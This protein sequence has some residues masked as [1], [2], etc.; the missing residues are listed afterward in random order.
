MK[1]TTEPVYSK[2]G[3]SPALARSPRGSAVRFTNYLSFSPP[4]SAAC[5]A[6][7]RATGTLNGE[8]LT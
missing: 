8:Q 7:N 1:R 4:D 5:A 6:A 2:G 3:A